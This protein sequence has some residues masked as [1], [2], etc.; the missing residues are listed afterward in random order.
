M[1]KYI[2]QIFVSLKAVKEKNLHFLLNSTI[3]FHFK[4]HYSNKTL[5]GFKSNVRDMQ[6]SYYSYVLLRQILLFIYLQFNSTLS[7]TYILQCCM[8][9][10]ETDVKRI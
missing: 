5:C 2:V 6:I 10:S 4:N 8:T 1:H 3:I 9:A 7:V